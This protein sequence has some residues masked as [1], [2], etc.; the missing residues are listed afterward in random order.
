MKYCQNCGAAYKPG[1]DKFCTRCGTALKVSYSGMVYY[2]LSLIVLG[3]LSPA[4][5]IWLFGDCGVAHLSRAMKDL[6]GYAAHLAQIENATV[7]NVRPP[8]YLISQIDG[9]YAALSYAEYD[10]CVKPA[11]DFMLDALLH[12]SS[13]FKDLPVNRVGDDG[14]PIM[15]ERNILNKKLQYEN[16]LRNYYGQI[17]Q[18]KA[19]H[20]FCN[21]GFIFKFDNPFEYP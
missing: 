13:F 11:A 7:D 14:Y 1:V 10:G 19:C 3:L 20:P 8:S 15:L 9:D 16:A 2:A 12:A 21:V 4:I 5:L 17:E 18:L 6:E